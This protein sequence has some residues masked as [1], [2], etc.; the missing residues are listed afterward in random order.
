LHPVRNAKNQIVGHLVSAA[1][2]TFL[3]LTT[4]KFFDIWNFD[5]QK[6]IR[7]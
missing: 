3:H 7:G 6:Q 2:V 4:K 5:I 1:K